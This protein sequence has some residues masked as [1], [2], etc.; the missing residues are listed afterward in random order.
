MFEAIRA[1]R[2]E[3]DGNNNPAA[4]INKPFPTDTA[5]LPEPLSDTVMV[6]WTLRCR[7]RMRL[8]YFFDF[9]CPWCFI[10]K[11]RLER[12]IALRDTAQVELH[13]QPFLLSSPRAKPTGRVTASGSARSRHPLRSRDLHAAVSEA[14]ATEG[15]VLH[16]NRIDRPVNTLAAHRMVRYAAARRLLPADMVDRIFQAHFQHEMDIGDLGVLTE[17]GRD[18][19]LERADLLTFLANRSEERTVLAAD[20]SARR[21]GI[22][23]IPCVVIDRRFAAAGAQEPRVYLPL[24]D[25]AASRERASAVGNG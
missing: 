20:A 13:W 4:R 9:A 10:G 5:T 19:G 18:A 2:Y 11:R 16:L 3:A 6:N 24:L 14:A 21:I 1:T 8:D 15:L 22:H 23:A 17:V 7:L 25:I 12:A